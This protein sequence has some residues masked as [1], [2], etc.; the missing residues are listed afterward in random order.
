MGFRLSPFNIC[1]HFLIFSHA[2]ARRA[3]SKE[4]W[5]FSASSA[6]PREPSPEVSLLK[7][8]SVRRS[9][10]RPGSAT[11]ATEEKLKLGKLKVEIW[12]TANSKPAISAF[13]FSSSC[14]WPV[15]FQLSAFSFQ[16]WALGLLG[17]VIIPSEALFEEDPHDNLRPSDGNQRIPWES[18][19]V[20]RMTTGSFP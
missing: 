6:A 14:F 8:R 16:L 9:E 5:I 18:S 3:R 2:E 10:P 15:A 17:S 20:D 11:P 1:F 7:R 13:N 12:R 4:D 19:E